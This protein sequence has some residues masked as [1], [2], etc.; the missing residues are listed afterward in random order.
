MKDYRLHYKLSN[1]GNL[2]NDVILVTLD[3]SSLYTN[4]PQNQGI[5][6]CR[7]LLDTRSNNHIPTKT[8]G[9]LRNDDGNGCE[10]IT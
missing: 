5:D 3:V 8:L 10:N 7:N 9:S 6:A 1:L 4:I 2:P